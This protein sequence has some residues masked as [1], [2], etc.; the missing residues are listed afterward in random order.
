MSGVETGGGLKR[1]ALFEEHVALGART[2]PFA[3]WEMPLRYPEG[4][5]AEHLAVRN[6]VGIFDVGHLGSVRV[7]GTG[8]RDALNSLFTNDLGKVGPGRAQYTLLL[9]EQGGVVDD[10]IVWWLADDDFW[11]IPNAANTVAVVEALDAL[12][13]LRI[14]DKSEEMEIIAVQGPRWREVMEAAGLGDAAVGRFAV[15]AFDRGVAAGTGYTGERGCELL[16]P[17]DAAVSIWRALMDAARGAGGAPAG[18]GARDTLR[19]EMGYPLCGNEMDESVT[20]WESALGW[21]VELGKPAFCGK[22]AIAGGPEEAARRLIGVLMEDR[23][24][25]RAGFAVRAGGEGR[26]TSGNYSPVLE[27]GIGLARVPAAALGAALSVEVSIRGAWVAAGRV[28]PPFV[29]TDS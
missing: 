26:M 6:A 13:G 23:Q 22:E 2:C 12:G 10:I 3:G 25:P 18:I 4:T 5:V 21:V 27:R 8:A 11:V 1:T 29:A 14:S 9:N 16:V 7:T 28:R 17:G 20:P 15:G 19:L 24:I